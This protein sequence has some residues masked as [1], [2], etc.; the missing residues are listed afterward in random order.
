M[1]KKTTTSTSPVGALSQRER[2]QQVDETASN[3]YRLRTVIDQW[4]Q[5]RRT[6]NSLKE[7]WDL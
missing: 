6:E 2:E 4:K 7:V 1:A 3:R 5:D